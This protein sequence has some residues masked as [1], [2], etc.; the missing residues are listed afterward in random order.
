MLLCCVELISDSALEFRQ[1]MIYRILNAI[2]CSFVLVFPKKCLRKLILVVVL[3]MLLQVRMESFLQLTIVLRFEVGRWL[4][5]QVKH[6]TTL[7]DFEKALEENL[8]WSEFQWFA[9]FWWLRYRS[10]QKFST[11]SLFKTWK[12]LFGKCWMIHILKA[13]SSG[14]DIVVS[15][16]K[17]FNFQTNQIYHRVSQKNSI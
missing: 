13:I 16:F 3:L 5:Y 11:W 8:Y 6:R 12:V 4:D 14:F 9:I 1:R 15:H 7:F 2:V 10:K 17:F